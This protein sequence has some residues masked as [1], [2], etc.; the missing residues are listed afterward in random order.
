MDDLKDYLRNRNIIL[1]A[2]AGLSISLGLPSWRE[3]FTQIAHQLGHDEAIFHNSGDYLNLAE[4][5]YLKTGSIGPLR[6]WMDR[7]FH[8]DAVDIRNSEVHQRIIDLDFPLI[9]TTNYDRWLERAFEA[10]G[11]PYSKIVNVRDLMRA[12]RDATQIVKF[13]GDFD[14]DDSVVLTETNYF[15]RLRFESPLDIKLRSDVLARSILFVGYSLQDINIRYLMFNLAKMW[16]DSDFPTARPKNFIFLAKPNDVQ[17]EV[18]KSRGIIPII[19]RSDDPKEGLIDFLKTLQ[20]LKN[21]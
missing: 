15:E 11:K 5:Y 9:Y 4:Y 13:H 14:D 12:K 19:S 17:E 18:L 3:L 8:A 16:G 20:D 7:Q 10:H 21:G 2:G 1:F 6:S